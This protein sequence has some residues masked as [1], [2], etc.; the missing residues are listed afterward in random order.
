MQHSISNDR[1]DDMIRLNSLG[2]SLS[3]IAKELGCHTTTVTTRLKKLNIPPADTRRAFM[4]DVCSSLTV[5]Q[6]AWLSEE[7]GPHLSVKD[8]ILNLLAKEYLKH[9]NK[10]VPDTFV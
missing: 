5:K 6:L 8:Y 2:L 9:N 3:T 4:E 7:L 1:T 10:A